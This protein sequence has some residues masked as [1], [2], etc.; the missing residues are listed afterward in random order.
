LARQLR[1]ESEGAID[2]EQR[3]GRDFLVRQA[4]LNVGGSAGGN[5]EFFDDGSALADAEEKVFGISSNNQDMPDPLSRLVANIQARV[6]GTALPDGTTANSRKAAA[7]AKAKA[8]QSGDSTPKLQ[9]EACV[10]LLRQ[11]REAERECF[12]LKRT[13]DVWNRLN[14]DALSRLHPSPTSFPFVP[15][16]CS[17]CAEPVALHF[18][19]LA[20]GILR[21][22][23]EVES[24]ITGDFVAA[25]FDSPDR[26]SQLGDLKRL[27]IVTLVEKSRAGAEMVLKELR[28]RSRGAPDVAG[29]EILGDILPKEFSISEKYLDLA[30]EILSRGT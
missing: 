5:I 10:T 25:L 2:F 23:V 13:V 12:A 3:S 7:K 11:M 19:L 8:K 1:T 27:A 18:L 30:V 22:G 29:V 21:A 17:V 6:R 4:L 28:S 16:L 24:A 9:M 15:S 14:Q 26:G 20:L